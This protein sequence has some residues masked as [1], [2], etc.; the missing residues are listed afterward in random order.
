MAV[1]MIE[2]NASRAAEPEISTTPLWRLGFRPFYLLGAVFAVI[3]VPLWL[4]RYYGLLSGL[5]NI[6]FNWHMHEMVFGFAVAIVVGFL[7]TAGRNWTNL[8]TPRGRALVALVS[9][10]IAGRIAMLF[11]APQIAAV[12]DIAFLPVAAFLLYQVLKKA[13]SKRNLV[14][15]LL[16]G[17]LAL[18]NASFH[19]TQLGWSELSTLSSIH[20][21]LLIIVMIETLIGGRVVP[22]FTA[23]FVPGGQLG[24]KPAMEK[25]VIASTV[26]ACL[27]WLAQP[28]AYVVA[29][30]ALA[31]AVMQAARLISWKPWHTLDNPLLWILHLS[32]AWISIGFLLL[33]LAALGMVSSSAAIHALAI[34]SMAG[35]IIGMITRTALGHTARPLKAGKRETIM[36]VLIQAGAV[37]RL[38]AS[39]GMPE[40]RDFL[41]LLSAAC[42][43][44]AFLLYVTV[45]LP[46]LTAPRLDRKDG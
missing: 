32:Y 33:G 2:E 3:A 25:A 46:Y 4:A 29:I 30:L 42:W 16:L 6:D 38:G 41:M 20:A 10:W 43:S 27:A 1:M 37:A 40:A 35:L 24:L 39:L 12:V 45:Y 22:L 21:A 23:K 7:Y 44:A 13:P 5:T 19:A 36:Y 14:M 34:G 11:A 17:L 28:A 18:A 26:A 9:L 31:A 8:W 15:V